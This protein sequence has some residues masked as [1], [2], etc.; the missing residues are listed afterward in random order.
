MLHIQITKHISNVYRETIDISIC[1]TCN[2]C[3]YVYVHVA[4]SPNDPKW[5][6]H[7]LSLNVSSFIGQGPYWLLMQMT[8]CGLNFDVLFSVFWRLHVESFFICQPQDNSSWILL[9]LTNHYNKTPFIQN[10]KPKLWPHRK[11]TIALSKTC[12]IFKTW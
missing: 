8:P 4:F 11:K 5:F 12:Q 10:S 1:L 6:Q 2:I 7:I 3:D 9:K